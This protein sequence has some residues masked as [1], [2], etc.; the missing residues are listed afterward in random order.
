MSDHNIGSFGCLALLLLLL[1]GALVG[2]AI[3]TSASSLMYC[4]RCGYSGKIKAENPGSFAVEILLWLLFIIPGL[5][6]SLWRIS[7][8]KRTCPNCGGKDLIPANSPAVKQQP[9]KPG[10]VSSARIG[11]EGAPNICIHCG[12]PNPLH[13]AYC[14]ACGK[15]FQ[16]PPPTVFCIHCGKANSVSSRY[17]NSCGKVVKS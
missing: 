8:V 11:N 16:T 4:R 13:A 1:I 2:N 14:N 12:K 6:Y 17:C 10:D 15:Q 5:I 9:I 3:R 7:T